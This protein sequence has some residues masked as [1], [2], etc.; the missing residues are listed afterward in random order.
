MSGR[1]WAVSVVAFAF[2]LAFLVCLIGALR[3]GSLHAIVQRANGEELVVDFDPPDLAQPGVLQRIDANTTIV[4][5]PVTIKN[6]ADAPRSVVGGTADCSCVA[7][8]RFPQTIEPGGQASI[9]VSIKLNSGD[10]AIDHVVT[11]YTDSPLNSVVTF[12]VV[13][14]VH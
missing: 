11:F 3:S 8:G 10:S 6:Y 7:T 4:H 9:D 13:S 12:R 5:V 14:R 2:L 1:R